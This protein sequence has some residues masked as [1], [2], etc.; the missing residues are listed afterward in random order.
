M[1]AVGQK[2]IAEAAVGQNSPCRTPLQLWSVL[3]PHVPHL[4]D[5]PEPT[6]RDCLTAMVTQM[7]SVLRKELYRICS[8]LQVAPAILLSLLFSSSE[9]IWGVICL[10]VVMKSSIT[11]GFPAVEPCQCWSLL[12]RQTYLSCL[13]ASLGFWQCCGQSVQR[14][15][16]PEV[17][18]DIATIP[19]LT[20]KPAN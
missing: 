18:S 16:A 11:A 2:G 12:Q 9:R 4:S 3:V 7:L 5:T 20:S 17:Y 6:V 14:C 8:L 19:D 13:K 1:D 15:W 10:L